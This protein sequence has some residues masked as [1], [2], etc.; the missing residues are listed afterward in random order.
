MKLSALLAAFVCAV[1]MAAAQS[2]PNPWIAIAGGKGPGH[3]KTV[4]LIAGDEEYRS[5]E[6]FLQLAKILAK[7]HGFNCIV[8]FAIDPMD[9]TVNPNFNSNIPGLEN[10]KKADLMIMLIR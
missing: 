1:Q 5:E 8:L 3:G 2:K 4:V 6:T 7:R 10:L 9:G